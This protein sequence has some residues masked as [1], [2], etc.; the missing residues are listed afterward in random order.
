MHRHATR[1]NPPTG[2]RIDKSTLLNI[3]ACSCHP[4]SGTPPG[5]CKAPGRCAVRRPPGHKSGQGF[6]V[7]P[8]KGRA[9]N[10]ALP[11][12]AHRLRRTDWPC[13]GRAISAGAYHSIEPLTTL[14]HRKRGKWNTA[15]P[16]TCIRR[17]PIGTACSG[18]RR[19][20]WSSLNSNWCSLTS[21]GALFKD[22]G[23][24]SVAEPGRRC[25]V[26]ARG[27]TR[28]GARQ[29]QGEVARGAPAAERGNSVTAA[30]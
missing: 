12:D 15:E 3:S 8:A 22:V 21:A 28:T 11:A 18:S 16:A 25:A 5:S 1:A 30:Q 17:N 2:L 26:P 7:R 4:D 20:V 13:W 19:P 14:W 23:I 9:A 6:G 29:G 10:P 24:R 27:E